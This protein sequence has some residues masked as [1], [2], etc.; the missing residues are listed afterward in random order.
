[1]KPKDNAHLQAGTAGAPHDVRFPRDPRND[2]PERKARAERA[3]PKLNRLTV[4]VGGEAGFG[5]AV[6]GLMLTRA[7]VRGGLFAMDYTEYPSLIRGGH[8]T[9]LLRV[10]QKPVRAA[11]A[12]VNVLI[13]LNKAS[14]F[15]HED[16][17]TDD[18]AIIYDSDEVEID[19]SK[20]LKRSSI[21]LYGVPL[22]ALAVGQGGE[23]LMRNVAGLGAF[24]GITGF[25]LKILQEV[26]RD[27]F[28]GKGKQSVVDTNIAIAT[29]GYNYVVDNFPEQFTYKLK[30]KEQAPERLALTGSE[31][32]ALGAIAAGCNFYS[33]Y[34]MTPASPVLHY[35]AAKQH[36]AGMVVQHA[37]DEIAAINQAIGASFAG[38]RAMTGSSGGGFALMTEA[39]GLAAITETPL[40]IY[41]A[42]RPGPA[43]GL[44]TWT[45]QADLRF[46]L[47][48]A[49]GEFPRVILAPGDVEESFYFTHQ[50][51]NL[52]DRYQLP[53][54]ILGDK[55]LSESHFTAPP[56][57]A[58]AL[59]IDR[60]KR[61]SDAE[62]KKLKRRFKR[63]EITEDGV[64]PRSIPGQEGGVFMA[65]SDEH[66]EFGYSSEDARMR[67]A[68]VHKRFAKTKALAAEVPEPELHGPA[69]ADVTIVGWGSTKG[70]VLEALDHLA[71]AGVT[72]NFY[73]LTT[74]WPFPVKRT[75]E[76]LQK[77]KRTLLVEANF[78]GQLGG[79]IREQTGI[80]IRD[81][82]LKYDGRPIYP[83][84]VYHKVLELTRG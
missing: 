65:N 12:S 64:S 7:L 4:K 6:S 40:V 37:E 41:E 79:L 21:R 71:E 11:I 55:Y 70:A 74:L 44:P 82:F 67:V 31:A 80:A 48:A 26:I 45:D 8:N 62:L 75:A 16:E 63:Y 36:E 61:V 18:G 56:F 27:V 73:Q 23:K 59:R 22:E 53:V 54:F 14:I 3:R 43:T 24:L 51:F 34:P 29:A 58:A 47:H 5:I 32:V 2:P 49:Q 17:L 76:V 81:R 15:L 19:P 46:V 42:Q 38:A 84:E 83:E 35:L 1:M 13:A 33:A 30:P 50:A 69:S 39:L 57:Q 10:D 78:T 72:A 77:A 68:Q 28:A 52:A 66:D 20:D 9:F 60:G 25:P